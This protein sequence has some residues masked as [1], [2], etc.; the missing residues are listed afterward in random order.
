M[1]NFREEM[2]I[3]KR[4][5]GQRSYNKEE[6][7]LLFML[8]NK[9]LQIQKGDTNFQIGYID[10][11]RLKFGEQTLVSPSTFSRKFGRSW[12]AFMQEVSKSGCS[13]FSQALDRL[14]EEFLKKP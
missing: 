9:T 13:E 3:P 8:L 5:F 4:S 14:V 7:F 6:L 11:E 12:K 10:L 2:G 1:D